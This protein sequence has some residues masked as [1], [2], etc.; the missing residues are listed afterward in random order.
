MCSLAIRTAYSKLSLGRSVIFE[1]PQPPHPQPLL[2]SA[3]PE[4]RRSGILHLRALEQP[5]HQNSFVFFFSSL[6]RKKKLMIS[7][8]QCACISFIQSDRKKKKNSCENERACMCF[9]VVYDI[10]AVDSGS[11]SFR[12]IPDLL[13]RPPWFESNLYTV[14]KEFDLFNFIPQ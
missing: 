14:L 8:P 11:L 13:L 2:M 9:I 5:F 3:H 12:Q 1:I 10:F 6:L 7:A 4:L